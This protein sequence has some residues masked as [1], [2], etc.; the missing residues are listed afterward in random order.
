MKNPYMV[1]YEKENQAERLRTEIR[2]LLVVIPLLAEE[3]S[4]PDPV[5]EPHVNSGEA[6]LQAEDGMLEL[7]RYYPFIR[8]LRG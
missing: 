1:L 5:H 7:K 4:S 2:A 3:D 6:V 8:H